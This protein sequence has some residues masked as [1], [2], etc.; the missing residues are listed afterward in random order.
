ML[1]LR[2]IVR[3]FTTFSTCFH[4]WGTSSTTLC[5]GL[6]TCMGKG[7][8]ERLFNWQ[9]VTCS[10]VKVCFKQLT[11][12]VNLIQE[13]GVWTLDFLI[14]FQFYK[15]LEF[16]TFHYIFMMFFQY[17][18][19]S[20]RFCFATKTAQGVWGHLQWSRLFRT[21]L[22]KL[23]EQW[24]LPGRS[25]GALERVWDERLT[26]WISVA[27]KS[28]A[29]QDSWT[30]FDM[31]LISTESLSRSPS[32]YRPFFGAKLTTTIAFT[33]VF[34][35]RCQDLESPWTCASAKQDDPC[36]STAESTESSQGN[37][38]EPFVGRMC[39]GLRW[40]E[41]KH[42]ELG[43]TENEVCIKM[44]A[45]GSVIFSDSLEHYQVSCYS[46]LETAM[47]EDWTLQWEIMGSLS[48]WQ[49]LL[50][51]DAMYHV[52][53]WSQYHVLQE[54]ATIWLGDVPVW[55]V[56]RVK[57][58]PSRMF[59]SWFL[60]H[61]FKV[62]RKQV[63]RCRFPKRVRYL[64][65]TPSKFCWSLAWKVP[66]LCITWK[67]SR[68]TDG[69]PSSSPSVEVTRRRIAVRRATMP[70]CACW[71]RRRRRCRIRRSGF[72]V[73]L[74]NACFF[75]ALP[76]SFGCQVHMLKACREAKENV[77]LRV[78]DEQ[79]W[80]HHECKEVFGLAWIALKVRFVRLFCVF[81]CHLR[82]PCWIEAFETFMI[83]RGGGGLVGRGSFCKKHG[84]RPSF[85]WT[86]SFR[87]YIVYNT[88]NMYWCN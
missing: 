27:L 29:G 78:Q 69:T 47:E 12:E 26:V 11:D 17:S 33:S 41:K 63:P 44:Q 67:G 62:E 85:S 61:D 34:G 24:Q 64:S 58:A 23:S 88:C 35:C 4:L 38:P 28:I 9:C 49:K 84:Q 52:T 2:A 36:E 79:L 5:P 43:L 86:P 39:L 51:L 14:D 82:M 73:F 60:N 7:K 21:D 20:L 22:S 68:E 76:N 25:T 15:L 48:R 31:E 56:S 6:P 16:M 42:L 65:P 50:F 8:C 74:F 40:L 10:K 87:M 30:T 54:I 71:I 3:R 37:C 1:L 66:W 53:G 32:P 46:V 70:P 83:S 19:S 59:L 72:G 77:E 18:L 13:C 55:R 75:V 80:Q 57:T 45:E 81:R